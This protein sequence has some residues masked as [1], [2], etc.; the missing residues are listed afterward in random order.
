M[1]E[2]EYQRYW[3]RV[4]YYGFTPE[5]AF[6]APIRVPLWIYRVEQEEG[7]AFVDFLK[8]EFALGYSI[9]DVARSID[10]THARL[11][12]RIRKYRKDGLLVND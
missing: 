6:S 9:A 12:N 1:T 7:C 4:A 3:R 2:K 10:V 11:F 8:R 5:E